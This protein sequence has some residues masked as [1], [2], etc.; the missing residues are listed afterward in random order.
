MASKMVTDRRKGANAVAVVG[1]AQA[2][3]IAKAAPG[4]GE[5]VPRLAEQLE[6]VR[7]EMVD[8]DEAHEQ[9]IANDPGERD[10]R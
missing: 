1:K 10:T 9:E 6:A 5:T 3:E 4:V 7:D 2:T 8:A